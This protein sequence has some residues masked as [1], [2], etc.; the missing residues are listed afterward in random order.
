[1]GTTYECR[2]YSRIWT[3]LKKIGFVGFVGEACFVI[4]LHSQQDERSA[5]FCAP[6]DLVMFD[7]ICE[8]E[9]ES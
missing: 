3:V 7:T 8:W 6:A 5:E 9:G 4:G 2:T 1:M